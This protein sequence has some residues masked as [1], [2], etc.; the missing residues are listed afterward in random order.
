[1]LS[2]LREQLGFDGVVVTDALDMAG[3]SRGPR[4]PRGGRRWPCSP[5]PTCSAWAPTRTSAWSARC[6][7]R[8]GGRPVRA[9]VPRSG[10]SRPRTGSPGWS[11][12]TA[13]RRARR[14]TWR[15]AQLA[16]ARA[17]VTVEG[18]LPRPA[19]RRAWSRSTPRPTSRSATSPGG[20][21]PTDRG[22]TRDRT[23]SPAHPRTGRSSSRSATPTGTR[24]SGRSWPRSPTPADRRSWSS[25]AGPAR[26]TAGCRGS[27]RAATRVPAR[28][29][30][31]E[32]LMET[33]WDR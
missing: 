5:A 29:A 12:T 19:R 30:V 24:R 31:T 22:R 13:G 4:H 27:A 7:R 17:A 28:A 6:R 10:W 14:S 1:M 18:E 8:G 23:R 20:C 11:R 2:L 15:E 33:G 9:A 25:G 32:L 16:G 26:T 21:P 3:A